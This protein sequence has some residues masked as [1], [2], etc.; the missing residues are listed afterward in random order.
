MAERG[1]RN[2][3]DSFCNKIKYWFLANCLRKSEDHQ[4][5]ASKSFHAI[6]FI[7]TLKHC[8]DRE[9]FNIL[10]TIPQRFILRHGAMQ[11]VADFYRHGT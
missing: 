3:K 8:Q 1:L 11:S 7:V 10:L 5:N 2:I 4:D 6:K 9:R